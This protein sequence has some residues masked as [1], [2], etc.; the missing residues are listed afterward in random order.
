MILG[1]LKL[2][3]FEKTHSIWLPELV[4]AVVERERM[5]EGERKRRGR[6]REI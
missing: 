3:T 4:S 6:E 5:R 1:E 2:G